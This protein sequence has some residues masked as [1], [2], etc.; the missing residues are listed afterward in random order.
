MFDYA[1]PHVVLYFDVMIGIA[2]GLED[3]LGADISSPDSNIVLIELAVFV[4]LQMVDVW[5]VVLDYS[6]HNNSHED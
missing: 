6:V 4:V 3:F 5:W 1:A 2:A